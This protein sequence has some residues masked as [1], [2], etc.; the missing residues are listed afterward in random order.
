[1]IIEVIITSSKF[2]L[3]P[4]LED[5]KTLGIIIKIAKGFLIPPVKKIN[6]VSCIISITKKSKADLSES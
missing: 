3:I 2:V 1:M 4:R 5:A 6:S